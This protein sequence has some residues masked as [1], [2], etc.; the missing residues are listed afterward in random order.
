MI[1]GPGSA[2][3]RMHLGNCQGQ[4]VWR[5]VVVWGVTGD[6]GKE[7]DG[8]WISRLPLQIILE[9]HEW[10][11]SGGDSLRWFGEFLEEDAS[12]IGGF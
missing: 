5:T 6:D 12:Q 3:S 9:A 10:H 2:N 8:D 4:G 7:V 11:P 1:K